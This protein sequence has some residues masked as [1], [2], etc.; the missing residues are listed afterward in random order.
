MAV[1][2][3]RSLL[4]KGGRRTLETP[5]RSPSGGSVRARAA[6][7]SEDRDERLTKD[8]GHFG[9]RL[10][11]LERRSNITGKPVGL[12]RVVPVALQQPRRLSW[13][14]TEV[15]AA[16]SPA[17]ARYGL[18]LASPSRSSIR[19]ARPRSGGI[20]I[21]A[22]RLSNPQSISHGAR[23]SGPKRLY[24]LIVGLHSGQRRRVGQHAGDRRL[25]DSDSPSSAYGSSKSGRPASSEV[26][27]WTW[28][29]E[30]P[31]SLNGL[32]MNVASLSS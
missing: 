13:S 4:I 3:A 26:E 6:C 8:P 24:E 15:S 29:P 2:A 14:N 22:L 7:R 28:N 32:A 11:R 12:A 18:P 20:L 30:P 23:V 10:K 21:I 9:V 1:G 27:K 16:S 25:A 31:S 17:I 19:A 5:S